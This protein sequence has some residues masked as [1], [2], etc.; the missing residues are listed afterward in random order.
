MSPTVT[1]RGTIAVN[2]GPPY[3][4]TCLIPTYCCAVRHDKGIVFLSSDTSTQ[5]AHVI[6]INPLLSKDLEN[7][8]SIPHHLHTQSFIGDNLKYHANSLTS[9]FIPL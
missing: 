7:F 4:R 9:Y 3:Q 2:L 6:T 8:T 5:A 1:K